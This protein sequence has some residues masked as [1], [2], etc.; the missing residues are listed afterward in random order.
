MI[1]AVAA[2]STPSKDHRHKG[3]NAPEGNS[4]R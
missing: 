4:T 3:A 2:E 1:H